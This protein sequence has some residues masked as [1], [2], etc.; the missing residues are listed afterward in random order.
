MAKE[1]DNWQGGLCE[2]VT[3]VGFLVVCELSI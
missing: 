1:N 2:R 3:G